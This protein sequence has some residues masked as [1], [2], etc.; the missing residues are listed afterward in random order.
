MEISQNFVA[1]SEYMNFKHVNF[2]AANKYLIIISSLPLGG[3]IELK[4]DIGS[5]GNAW[6]RSLAFAV[7]SKGKWSLEVKN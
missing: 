1:F 5:S 2:I 7:N 3:V 4:F 6:S